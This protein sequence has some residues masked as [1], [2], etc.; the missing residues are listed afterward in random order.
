MK[1][2]AFEDYYN[3]STPVK[4][5]ASTL[6]IPIGVSNCGVLE[7]TEI[8][9]RHWQH[10]LIAGHAGSGK[11]NYLHSVLASLLLNY[12]ADQLDI[13]LEDGGMCDAESVLAHIKRVNTCSNPEGYT[14]FLN[15]LEVEIDNRLKYLASVEKTSFYACYRE[16]NKCPF[17]R[18]IIMVDGFDHFVRYLSEVNHQ[19]VDKMEYIVRRASACGITFIVSTQEALFLAQHISRSYFELFGIRVATRQSPDSYGVLFN[20][21]AVELA[22]NLKLGE[23]ITSISPDRKTNMLYISS[24]IERKIAEK[25]K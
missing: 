10:I 13:W 24:E 23:M 14:A 6:R 9:D 7:E 16:I 5:D 22:C 2:T 15:T 20:P 12:S 8:T 11:S 17:P 19:Y 3:L 21:S 25:A 4:S 1:L 18:V